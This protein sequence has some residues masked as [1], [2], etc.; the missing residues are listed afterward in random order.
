M[1]PEGR[2]LSEAEE[3][4][5]WLEAQTQR[6]EDSLGDLIGKDSRVPKQSV[7]Q[8][9]IESLR[10]QVMVLSDQLQQT[11]LKGTMSSSGNLGGERWQTEL[12]GA[13]N[14]SGDLRGDQSR[15][16]QNRYVAE[17]FGDTDRARSEEPQKTF[18]VQWLYRHGVSS[19]VIGRLLDVGCDSMQVL[20]LLRE[21]DWASVG[22]PLGKKRVL[23]HALSGQ[24]G[25]QQGVSGQGDDHTMAGTVRVQRFSAQQM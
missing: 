13:V 19:D 21:D 1:D 4:V 2:K 11:E 3:R 12:G 5:R 24:G 14:G 15:S 20:Q 18:M 25:G 10:E 23:Q 8:R 6:S 16:Q 22:V 7:V 17:S 9:E